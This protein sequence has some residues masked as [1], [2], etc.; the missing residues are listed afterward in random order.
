MVTARAVAP[1]R[2]AGPLVPHLCWADGGM[3]L[4]LKGRSA[5]DEVAAATG[6]CSRAKLVADVLR[7]RAHPDAEPTTVVRLHPLTS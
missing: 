7:V 4:A 3:L 1:L 6:N 5:A 2:P